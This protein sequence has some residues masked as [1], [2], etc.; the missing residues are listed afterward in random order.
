MKRIQVGDIFCLITPNTKHKRFFQFISKDVSSLSSDVIRVFKKEYY[1]NECPNI[2]DI[3]E[4]YV[5]D[6]LHTIIRWGIK[7]NLWEYYGNSSNIGPLNIVFRSSRDV[8]EHPGQIYISKRW[9]VWEL[10]KRVRYVGKLPKRYYNAAIGDVS[11]PMSAVEKI[12]EHSYVREY[13]PRY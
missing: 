9:E 3:V 7:L 4:D 1:L 8:G 13:Y 6:Y 11:G 12:E 2:S 10:N 5:E